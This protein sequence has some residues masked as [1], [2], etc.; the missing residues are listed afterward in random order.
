MNIRYRPLEIL[1]WL[2]P[3][4]GP[5]IRFGRIVCLLGPSANQFVFANSNLFRWRE[6]FDVLVQVDGGSTA[7]LVSD[8]AEHQRRR[9]AVQPALHH[10]H[11][12]T[13]LEIM[14]ENADAVLAGWH[15]GELV[16]VY[17]EF[18]AAILNSTVQSLFGNQF[19]EHVSFFG[20]HVQSLLDMVERVPIIVTLHRRLRTPQWRRAMVARAKVDERVY[21]EIERA[22]AG[23]PAARLPAYSTCWCIQVRSL[24][25]KSETKS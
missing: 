24:I 10:R 9:R 3:R 22:R 14:S 7:L 16:D 15:S 20:D 18:R 19:A 6:A 1:S 2:Y 5:I 8:G 17:E 25:K 4:F 12:T 13:F 11:V 21:A 23:A